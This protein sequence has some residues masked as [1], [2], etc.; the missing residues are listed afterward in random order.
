MEKQRQT[1]QPTSRRTRETE[2]GQKAGRGADGVGGAET[3]EEGEAGDTA[4][5]LR[6]TLP[7]P[8]G[9]APLHAHSLGADTPV[10]GAEPQ[11]LRVHTCT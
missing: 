7:V 5:T 3:G 1:G 9:P 4:E 8:A 2:R 6:E 10:G 11:L